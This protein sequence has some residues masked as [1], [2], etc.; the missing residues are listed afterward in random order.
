[1]DKQ[2]KEQVSEFSSKVA[3]SDWTKQKESTSL[4]GIKLILFMYRIGGRFLVYP[5]LYIIVFFVY[6]F[7][8]KARL[9]SKTYLDMLAKNSHANKV[10]KYSSY[11]HLFRFCESVLQKLLAWNNEIKI[12]EIVSV[13]NA[14]E[15]MRQAATR[16]KGGVLISAHIGNIEMM[17][18]FN[19]KLVDKK[20]HVLLLTS[21]SKKFFNV[22]NSLDNNS[23]VGIIAVDEITPAVSMQLE[24]CV[25]KGDW[26]CIMAD[27]ILQNDSRSIE[28]E[29]LGEK[30]KFP[31]G[32]WILAHLLKAPVYTVYITE[33]NGKYHLFYNDWGEI[34]LNRRT[35]SEDISKYVNKFTSEIASV[36]ENSPYDW[37]NIY[38]FWGK[39]MN[40]KDVDK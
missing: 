5:I 21:N 16:E 20:I 33:V 35:R 14:L 28:V 22:I 36:L 34:T 25:N 4:F 40:S 2:E 27:R 9:Y 23:S 7:N 31:Q 1:M 11:K 6:L 32:P 37:F 39:F 26:V 12:E 8:K 24:E 15:R 17:R 29:F 38:D 13:D 30:A 19:T 10:K 3:Q 18:A